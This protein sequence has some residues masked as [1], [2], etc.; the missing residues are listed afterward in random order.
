[1]RH[2]ACLSLLAASVVLGLAASASRGQP[3]ASGTGRIPQF[4]NDQ[5]RVWKSVIVPHQPLVLHRHDHPRVVVVLAGGTLKI[6]EQSGANRTVTWESG[7]AYWLDPDPPGTAHG[8]L[9]EGPTPIEVM[10]VELRR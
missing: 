10:V 9:N 6:V 7:R 3:A 5:V 8:D 2:L 1:M 4:E